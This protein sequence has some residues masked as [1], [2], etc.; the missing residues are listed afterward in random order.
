MVRI[1]RRMV[2]AVVLWNWFVGW[3]CLFGSIAVYN[4]L[5]GKT[6]GAAFSVNAWLYAGAFLFFWWVLACFLLM[7][8]THV[9]ECVY[10]KSFDVLQD[11]AWL[12]VR[13]FRLKARRIKNVFIRKWVR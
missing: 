8:F 10:G 6:E 9:V 12:Y 7:A 4:T 1:K 5:Q 3:G 11:R 2:A 13:L